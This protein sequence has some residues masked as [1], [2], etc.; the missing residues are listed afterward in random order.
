[1]GKLIDLT[2]Q[3]FGKW[4]VIERVENYKLGSARFLCI[5]ECGNKKEVHGHSLRIG[6]SNSCGCLP[7]EKVISISTKHGKSNSPEYSTWKHIKDRCTNPNDGSYKNYGGRGITVCERWQNDFQ[8]FLNDMGE[9]PSPEHSIERI[10]VNGNYE[11]NNCKWATRL[12]Q[13][14]N[15]R[16]K[17]NNKTGYN[18]IRQRKDNGKYRV[19]IMDNGK[20][21]SLGD[22]TNLED[23]IN[24]RK[25]AEE[26]YWKSS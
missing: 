22:Y 5:C 11:P 12:E 20:Q 19:S 16:V 23:A 4:T 15:R 10:E 24:A 3:K 18:G 26:K 8:N 13:A 9:K 1:M 2:G 7:R 6:S 17:K 14:H 21:I 25:R